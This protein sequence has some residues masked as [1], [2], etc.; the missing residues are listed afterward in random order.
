MKEYGQHKTRAE[1][2]YE[3]WKEHL[4]DKDGEY[5]CSVVSCNK[6]WYPT[7]ED[8]N[9]KRPSTYY[10]LCRVCRTKSYLKGLEYKKKVGTNNYDK[11]RD[12]INNQ[13]SAKV[14]LDTELRL[15]QMV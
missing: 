15:E 8:T 7:I 12:G 10:K 1:E 5:R 2:E 14:V 6:V 3:K 9:R 4:I 13:T 11:L